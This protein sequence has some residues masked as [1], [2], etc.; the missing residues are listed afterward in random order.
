MLA[1]VQAEQSFLGSVC[2]QLWLGVSVGLQDEGVQTEAGQRTHE[3]TGSAAL[4]FVQDQPVLSACYHKTSARGAH[5][6]E[7][8]SMAFW[9][10]SGRLG[11]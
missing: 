2:E 10:V 4:A 1:R 6:M 5:A 8:G 3:C 11:L 9:C 7:H